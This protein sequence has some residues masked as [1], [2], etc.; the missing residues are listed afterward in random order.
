[1]PGH[2]T[3]AHKAELAVAALLTERSVEAAALKAGISHGTLKNWMKKPRFRTALARARREVL[4]GT[5]AKILGA[6]GAAVDTLLVNLT[7]GEPAIENTAAKALVDFSLKGLDWCDMSDWLREAERNYQRFLDRK[8]EIDQ[9]LA[10]LEFVEKQLEEANE[11]E[12]QRQQQD[13]R[14]RRERQQQEQQKAGDLRRSEVEKVWEQQ[15]ER[16][17]L[18][19]RIA[20]EQEAKVSAARAAYDKSPDTYR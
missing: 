7:C 19:D 14:L 12:L 18:F 2:G 1:M 6:S 11:R 17:E 20:G 15:A 4:A 8:A 5:V 13:D 16:R 3:K 10:R 9:R